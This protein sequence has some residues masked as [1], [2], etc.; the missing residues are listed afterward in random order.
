MPRL[1][2]EHHFSRSEA[3][4]QAY[5][6]RVCRKQTPKVKN[7]R[8][9]FRAELP[10][11]DHLRAQERLRRRL[12]VFLK[13]WSAKSIFVDN[14][15]FHL[16]SHKSFYRIFKCVDLG[17][18]Q[19]RVWFWNMN[20]LLGHL[21]I[22]LTQIHQKDDL[23]KSLNLFYCRLIVARIFYLKLKVLAFQGTLKQ[24]EQRNES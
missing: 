8:L 14:M 15:K 2:N 17:Y 1:T 13:T 4:C 21:E 18:F 7:H 10:A 16:N 5:S 6:E 3:S 9:N 23:R 24:E 22:E 11:L 20:N 12:I 19:I